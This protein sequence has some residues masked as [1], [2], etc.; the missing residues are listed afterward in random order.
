MA[1]RVKAVERNIKFTKDEN[2]PDGGSDSDEQTS[3]D[4]GYGPAPPKLKVK[5]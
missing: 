2:D 1:L 5:S 4:W 3:G